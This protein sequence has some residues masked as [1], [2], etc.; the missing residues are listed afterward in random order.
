[1]PLIDA[2]GAEIPASSFRR[3]SNWQ[4]ATVSM[5]RELFMDLHPKLE[6]YLDFEAK[7][8]SGIEV[9]QT[10]KIRAHLANISMRHGYR[11]RW[12]YRISF[13]GHQYLSIPQNSLV[14]FYDTDRK[15][16]T[17]VSWRWRKIY[18]ADT[19]VADTPE[20]NMANV[21]DGILSIIGMRDVVEGIIKGQTKRSYNLFENMISYEGI[22]DVVILSNWDKVRKLLMAYGY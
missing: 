11:A 2:D 5:P 3:M 10:I 7:T 22:N 6:T 15:W 8:K 13:M 17:D 18:I 21:A 19:I 16:E 12:K 14:L 9:W 20:G 4:K 1:M